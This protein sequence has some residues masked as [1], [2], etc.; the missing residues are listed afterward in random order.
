[1]CPLKYSFRNCYDFVVFDERCKIKHKDG[2]VA[3]RETHETLL[4]DVIKLTV[5]ARVTRAADKTIRLQVWNYSLTMV[6]VF[7]IFYGGFLFYKS[8][9]LYRNT[10][11]GIFV[12]SLLIFNLKLQLVVTVRV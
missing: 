5:T 3:A 11:S 6:S 12:S 1:M 2:T 7:G 10:T 9:T 8:K 4:S